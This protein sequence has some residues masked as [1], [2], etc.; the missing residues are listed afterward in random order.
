MGTVPDWVRGNHKKVQ[1]FADGGV[2]SALEHGTTQ[3][4]RSYPKDDERVKKIVDNVVGAGPAQKL[5]DLFASVPKIARMTKSPSALAELFQSG[6]VEAA[7]N[8]NDQKK[9]KD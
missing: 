5:G 2:I 9:D 6:S 1:G 4:Q 7:Q 3:S 8:V